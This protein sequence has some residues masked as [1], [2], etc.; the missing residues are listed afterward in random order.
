MKVLTLEVLSG[1]EK[2][3]V[4]RVKSAVTIGRGEGCEIR[5]TDTSI[6]TTH[7]RID[8][9][10]VPEVTDLK[11]VNRTYHNGKEVKTAQLADG[12]RIE[13]GDTEFSV[14]IRE[15]EEKKETV[16]TPRNL[17]L[18]AIAVMLVLALF[19][20]YWAMDRRAE[21]VRQN[22]PLTAKVL[23]PSKNVKFPDALGMV[24]VNVLVPAEMNATPWMFR[25]REVRYP[26]TGSFR[27]KSN[28]DLRTATVYPP[29]PLS[30]FSYE[31]RPWAN[32]R[33]RIGNGR[34]LKDAG[35]VLNDYYAVGMQYKTTDFSNPTPPD[36]QNLIR[37]Q[38]GL[39]PLG[40]QMYVECWDGLPPSAPI[41]LLS[42]DLKHKEEPFGDRPLV[43]W[44][45]ARA[46]QRPWWKQSNDTMQ[47]ADFETLRG[48]SA[49]EHYLIKQTKN[50]ETLSLITLKCYD[51]QKDRLKDLMA[52]LMAAQD[53]TVAR[54]RTKGDDFYRAE[55]KRLES[56]ADGIIPDVLTYQ[57]AD[58]ERYREKSNVFRAFNRYHRALVMYQLMDKW[59][60]DED[61]VRVFKKATRVFDYVQG[62][63]SFFV[64][65]YRK[66]EEAVK[67]QDYQAALKEAN[68]LWQ[69]TL[70]GQEPETYVLDEWFIYAHLRRK[71]LNRKQ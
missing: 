71:F 37:T 14:T 62:P 32:F 46:V 15:V 42:M 6:S 31:M 19:L 29:D 51:W 10:P 47:F 68:S 23:G 52:Q 16:F 17:R 65:S 27:Y 60:N 45:F 33:P 57:S 11:S 66:I 50:G 36:F 69:V 63:E 48:G 4:Y 8:M 43:P 26:L 49:Y 24:K 9:D 34:F 54:K 70:E 20:I 64:I 3:R 67:N 59:P 30:S 56:E 7:C 53:T 2:G 40:L 41:Q 13:L 55:A 12:D 1:P 35:V 5:L 44:F 25:V 38:S 58:W 28:S 61:Y 18:A 39:T 22:T 21:L